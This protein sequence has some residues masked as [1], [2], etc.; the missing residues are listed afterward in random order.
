MPRRCGQP[1]SRSRRWRASQR[2]PPRA[3]PRPPGSR[4]RTVPRRAEGYE[5]VQGFRSQ[6]AQYVDSNKRPQ[7][8][9]SNSVPQVMQS[10]IRAVVTG[11]SS[12]IGEATARRLAREPGAEL[13][14][15][16]RREDRLRAL[17]ESLPC[18]ATYVAA[19]LTDAEA[20]GRIAAHVAE[21]GGRLT[22]LV[23]NAGASW[24][25]GFGE[26]GYAN[27]QRHMEI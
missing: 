1:R 5:V 27:L 6:G 4:S 9:V 13:I 2:R 18:G 15:V 14:L 25:G 7:S 17:V 22:L 8:G 16:A 12:G 26:A 19:D 21:H 3:R 20:P 11:A 24:R 10:G 23:N